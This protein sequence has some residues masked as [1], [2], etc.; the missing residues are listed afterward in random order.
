LRDATAFE[1]AE[2]VVRAFQIVPPGKLR[3]YQDV[4]ES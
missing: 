4:G 3:E 1:P 2:E